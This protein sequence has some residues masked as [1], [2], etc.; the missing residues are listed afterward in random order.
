M[1][2]GIAK[3]LVPRL[4]R[5]F[6]GDRA[7]FMEELDKV[8]TKVSWVFAHHPSAIIYYSHDKQVI[9]HDVRK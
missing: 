3:A 6:P 9:I 4:L 5:D 7:R 2:S 8:R 1:G